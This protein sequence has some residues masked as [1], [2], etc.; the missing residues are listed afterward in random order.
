[1]PTKERSHEPGR[2]LDADAGD[3]PA[4][5]RTERDGDALRSAR[6]GVRPRE[7]PRDAREHERD[8]DLHGGQKERVVVG[9]RVA[10]AA[11]VA[12]DVEP[13]R[14][15]AS[16]EL[17]DQHEQAERKPGEQP[18]V[19]RRVHPEVCIEPVIDAALR[20]DV[21]GRAAHPSS[22]SVQSW[23]CSESSEKSRMR[24]TLPEAR[25]GRR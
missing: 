10:H 12:A 5:T 16:G 14:E 2:E 15:A 24:C 22:V 4:R 20:L 19:P 3:A 13:V 18:L 11:H 17:C 7:P 25:A 21:N 23:R 8:T 6:G 9:V 1:M